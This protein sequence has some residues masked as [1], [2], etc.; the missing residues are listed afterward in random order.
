MGANIT[1]LLNGRHFII[2]G[3]SPLKSATVKAED[4]RGGAALVLAALIAEGKT[5]IKGIE[6]IERGYEN[7][8]K[9]LQLVG[10]DIY[11]SED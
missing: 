4:L 3:V 9:D 2:S 5:T 7:I 11:K 8:V 1:S 10:A 6:Y